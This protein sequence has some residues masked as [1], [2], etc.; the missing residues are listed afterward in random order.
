MK[1]QHETQED[2]RVSLGHLQPPQQEDPLSK[3]ASAGDSNSCQGV[4]GTEGNL[5]WEPN[6]RYSK[7]FLGKRKKDIRDSLDWDFQHEIPMVNTRRS[8]EYGELVPAS[9]AALGAG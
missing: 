1:T 2:C 9:R 3:Q 6:A 4:T 7:A 8:K 5:S